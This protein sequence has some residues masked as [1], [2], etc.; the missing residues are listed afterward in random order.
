MTKTRCLVI[1]I[2][3][4]AMMAF[5]MPRIVAKNRVLNFGNPVY[6]NVFGSD[7][8]ESNRFTHLDN[9][10]LVSFDSNIPEN[11][12]EIASSPKLILYFNVEN[13][14]FILKNQITGYLWYSYSPK[15]NETSIN[16]T[17]KAQLL[18]PILIDV[19]RYQKKTNSL[20]NSPRRYSIADSL[21]KQEIVDNGVNL[22]LDFKEI[23]IKLMIEVRL[24][25][26]SLT[27][28]IPNDSIIEKE[29]KLAT[30]SLLPNFGST[31]DNDVP[32]YML[33]PDGPGALYRFKSSS[34]ARNPVQYS[35][36]YFET[37][38]GIK[39][40][41]E[42]NP[43]TQLSL[44]IFGMIQGVSQHGYL[45]IVEE[46]ALNSM[47][48]MTPSGA[49][50]MKYNST[51]AS[52]IYRESYVYP[53]NLKGDG[54]TMIQNERYDEDFKIAYYF[55]TPEDSTYI[56]LAKLYQSYLIN[57]GYLK[58]KSSN[59]TKLRLEILQ[60]DSQK[61]LFGIKP[62]VMTNLRS[63][64]DII[65][66]LLA[67][68][69]EL[70]VILK[71]WNKGGYSG[72]SPYPI[73]FES[74]IGKKSEYKKFIDNMN[75]LGISV[76]F[77]T[78]YVE[79]YSTSKT[80]N[81]RTDYAKGIYRR[82]IMN[83][84]DDFIYNKI[85]YVTPV[86]TSALLQED[87]KKFADYGITHLA[88]DGIS[89]KLFSTYD[90]GYLSRYQSYLN[91]Q[92]GLNTVTQSMGFYQP[93]AY[94]FKYMDSYYDMP[95][96]HSQLTFYDDT[97]PFLPIV[98][99]G[100]VDYYSPMMNFFSDGHL[101]RLMMLDY[102]IYPSYLVTNEDSNFLKFSKAR[103]Y[104]STKYTTWSSSIIEDF[105][106]LQKPLDLVANAN[107]SDR[108]VL[109]EGIVQ[110]FYS[111][112]ISFIINYTLSPYQTTH[113]RVEPLSYFIMEDVL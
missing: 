91:Y 90:N 30:I 83:E 77:Y 113:Y 37:D 41:S 82:Q 33:I 100:F 26:D 76:S 15:L 2:L 66:N 85:Y 97:I 72:H 96:Y 34:E 65:E 44:P 111:N 6:S 89:N 38:R 86:K 56:G 99:N 101:Q 16:P 52:I 9:L 88:M 60:G 18:S 102:G 79:T 84:T 13:S 92:E 67:S 3:I 51:G 73:E 57:Q 62:I 78:N 71:G 54:I 81:G 43:L 95:L 80:V 63:T 24:T 61:G 27:V 42:N 68:D 36:R 74:K 10:S 11:F 23:E 104:F 22:Y 75:N 59:K 21:V 46:G 112:G 32:G 49:N 14:T 55:T 20:A 45:G 25:I 106:Y 1:T 28:K 35:A 108:I 105:K 98:L 69:V 70:N 40:Q 103:N 29:N 47:F 53:V 4:M 5:L 93:N 50:G 107:I 39:Q 8:I 7:I 64:S 48:N 19:Y 12:I 94:N 87:S 17:L 58:E 31:Y 109:Q 110:V